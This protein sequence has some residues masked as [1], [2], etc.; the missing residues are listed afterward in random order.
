MPQ[1]D[2]VQATVSLSSGSQEQP[3]FDRSLLL[4][5]LT[6]AQDALFNGARYVTLTPTTW[7]AQLASLGISDGEAAYEDVQ[8]HFSGSRIPDVAYLGRRGKDQ[9]EVWLITVPASPADGSYIIAVNGI[10]WGTFVASSSSQAVVRTDLLADLAAGSAVFASAAG[11]SPGQILLTGVTDGV[12]LNVQVSSPSS[13]MTA[14][15]TT[16]TKI[17]AVAQV[18]E[19]EFNS[20]TAGVYEMIVQTSTGQKT[21]EHIAPSGSTIAQIRD[22]MVAKYALDPSDLFA[23][24]MTSVSTDKATLEASLAGR[25][26][27]VTITSPASD[28][29]ATVTTANYGIYDDILLHASLNKQWYFAVVGSHAEAELLLAQEAVDALGFNDPRMVAL[30]SSDADILTSVTTDVFSILKARGSL[31]G[32]GVYHPV[33]AEGVHS[34]W[35]ADVSTD[36][37]GQV[38]WH[39][40]P[41]IG[42]QGNYFTSADAPANIR[43]KEGSFLERFAARGQDIMNGGYSWAGRPID[44]TR[45]IDDLLFK[46]R[47]A[48]MDLI[49]NSRIIPYSKIGQQR[50]ADA[51]AAQFDAAVKQGYAIPGTLVLTYDPITEATPSDRNRGIFP[52]YTGSCTIQA[53]GHK[54]ILDFTVTQ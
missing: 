48:L 49:T 25:P 20:T 15:I 10:T 30:Q 54:F 6:D 34:A 26:G 41:L 37:V 23:N 40:R 38:Q 53:G 42:L 50:G 14:T 7:V 35:T 39:G 28:A 12:H 27:T 4:H 1:N 44:I 16:P 21:Y 43:A 52:T 45:G 24:T 46:F 5:T 9:K 31:R 51:I 17:A 29:T 32:F 47:S 36:R 33:D 19:V 2:F 3:A 18:W 8:D 11:G 22:A 13:S